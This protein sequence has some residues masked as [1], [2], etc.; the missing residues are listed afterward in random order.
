MKSQ[1]IEFVKKLWGMKILKIVFKPIINTIICILAY[2]LLG[3]LF[4]LE[5]YSNAFL[6]AGFII[7]ILALQAHIIYLR[8]FETTTKSQ[9]LF[10]LIASLI[11]LLI[12]LIF[13][14][15]TIKR[16]DL[17]FLFLSLASLPPFYNFCGYTRFTQVD[18]KTS[19]LNYMI[20]IM[21]VPFLAFLVYNHFSGTNYKT[22]YIIVIVAAYYFV[23][24][25]LVKIGVMVFREK[26]LARDFFNTPRSYKLITIC[27]MLA[28]PLT[29]LLMNQYLYSYVSQYTRQFVSSG[30]LSDNV[31]FFGDFSHPAFYLLTILNAILL[32]IPPEKY[33][34]FRLPMFFAKSLGFCFIFYMTVVFLPVLPVGVLTLFFIVGIYAF[35]P[36][37]AFWW[38]GRILLADY[39]ALKLDYANKLVILI[40]LLGF[41]TLPALLGSFF[42]YDKANFNKALAYT[43]EYNVNA[44]AK[45]DIAALRRSLDVRSAA[46]YRTKIYGTKMNAFYSYRNIPIISGA[47]KQFMY[48]GQEL[49]GDCQNRLDILFLNQDRS[50]YD[51]N[52]DYDN[53]F[54]DS[55]YGYYST[56]LE[57][58]DYYTGDKSSVYIEDISHNTTYDE[59]I[60]AYRTW[61]DLT[62]TNSWSESNEYK[63]SFRLPDG[64]Y[65]SNYYLDVAGERKMGLLADRRAALAVYRRIVLS[66]LDPG[67]LHYIDTDLL[68]LRVFPF[69]VYERRTTGFEIIHKNSFSLM[70]DDRVV[71]IE[72]GA[73]LSETRLP[74]AVLLSADEINS[75]P[76]LERAPEY[77]F[78]LDCSEK[79]DV[80]KLARFIYDYCWIND[81]YDGTVY[82]TTYRFEKI[83]LSDLTKDLTKDLA[84]TKIKNEGGF[85]I[86]LA[87][88]DIFGSANN[89]TPVI[90]FV[91]DAA[92]RSLMLPKEAFNYESPES[93]YYYRLYANNYGWP[94]LI[95]YSLTAGINHGPVTAPMFREIVSYNDRAVIRDG[96]D[97]LVI[98]DS[99][100]PELTGNQ[101]LD[102]IALAVEHRI[103]LKNGIKNPISYIQKSFLSHAL[104]PSTAFI[105]VETAEQEREL[106]EIQQRLLDENANADR[107]SG[108]ALSEP[109]IIVLTALVLLM[110]F[111]LHISKFLRFRKKHHSICK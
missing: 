54:Y 45:V 1:V 104:T 16:S 83:P 91:S 110:F 102:A 53:Y 38:Q 100:V 63:T 2:S 30:L 99:A 20:G 82:L 11:I 79:S 39:R 10:F 3:A 77:N 72:A 101:Y 40:S 106:L 57:S 95:A 43:D 55:E 75:L 66:R 33:Y 42:A 44:D 61:I 22:I 31:G 105:V 24:F 7:S 46:I 14:S 71:Q 60:D 96:E 32:L 27:L 94:G 107:E 17:F 56:D 84:K 89:S 67:I 50:Y 18:K 65:V 5:L 92:D 13:H 70:L 51:Y 58:V 93:S 59:S 8:K 35:V 6:I 85:N 4:Y 36:I 41:F 48:G 109:N 34:K 111:L 103:N 81:I 21:A 73:Q 108:R 15:L 88:K 47:Y 97:K 78:I 52:Y 29:G 64:A 12:M 68:E 80:S 62:L 69:D 74:G 49:S 90:I 28:M 25:S 76:P 37:L 87:M 23:V 26:N 19:L 98:T 9:H 86:G